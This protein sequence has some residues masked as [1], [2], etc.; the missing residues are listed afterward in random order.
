MLP[1]RRKLRSPCERLDG[2][3]KCTIGSHTM[4]PFSVLDSARLDPF[5]H[6]GYAGIF[7]R[8]EQRARYVQTLEKAG[9]EPAKL[10]LVDPDV[11]Y[12]RFPNGYTGA[13]LLGSPDLPACSVASPDKPYEM[14]V[15]HGGDDLKLCYTNAISAGDVICPLDRDGVRAQLDAIAA[16]G[17]DPDCDHATAELPESLDFP[18]AQSQ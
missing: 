9:L 3:S 5:D 13:V 10:V 15:M 4:Y 1:Q 6:A 7:D 16:L 2:W 18:E 12:Y 8:S 17:P 14:A 11:A